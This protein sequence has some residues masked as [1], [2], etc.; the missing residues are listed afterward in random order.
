MPIFGRPPQK[1]EPTPQ[2]EPDPDLDRQLSELE[3]V[4]A[5]RA[6]GLLDRGFLIDD[7]LKLIKRPDV[8]HD[9]DALLS[10]GCPRE[11]IVDNFTD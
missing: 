6:V 3:Q 5:W 4:V 10:K 11:F 1:P 9:V 2:D 7:V 8:L